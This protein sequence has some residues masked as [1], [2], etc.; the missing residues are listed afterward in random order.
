[1]TKFSYYSPLIIPSFIFFVRT[2]ST[3][4][5]QSFNIL[6][7]RKKASRFITQFLP[8]T[9]FF[10]SIS[11]S[12]VLETLTSIQIFLVCI[13]IVH[14][15]MT[16]TIQP[17]ITKIQLSDNSLDSLLHRTISPSLFFIVNHQ[18]SQVYLLTLIY[19][20]STQDIFEKSDPKFI[21]RTSRRQGF[22]FII[23]VNLFSYI[24]DGVW[25]A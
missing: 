18:F 21:K 4:N 8:S 14:P 22:S 25:N 23:T 20:K 5:T 1:M 10:I 13:H 19:S 16:V 6:Q 2:D 24:C 17:K 3:K 15:A 12:W 9:L 11:M 7:E